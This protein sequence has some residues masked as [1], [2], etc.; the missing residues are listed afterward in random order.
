[1]GDAFER[2]GEETCIQDFLGGNLTDNDK[3]EGL[4]VD[5]RIILKRIFKKNVLGGRGLD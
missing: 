5:G 1:V 4:D 3:F 2:M